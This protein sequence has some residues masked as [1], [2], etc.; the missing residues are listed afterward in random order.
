MGRIAPDWMLLKEA[1]LKVKILLW[2]PLMVDLLQRVPRNMTGRLV[3]LD[4]MRL[5]FTSSTTFALF[6]YALGTIACIF[7]GVR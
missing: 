7:V 5:R 1:P 2:A 4:A 6:S 3:N